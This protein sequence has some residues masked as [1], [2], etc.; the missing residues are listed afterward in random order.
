MGELDLW[1]DLFEVADRE[2]AELMAKSEKGKKPLP[3]G[4]MWEIKR[5]KKAGRWVMEEVAVPN[6]ARLLKKIM[7]EPMKPRKEQLGMVNVNQI[8]REIETTLAPL[9][10]T[11]RDLEAKW[12]IDRL[13]SL[14]PVDFAQRFASARSKLDDAI[15]EGE[16]TAV[17]KRAEIMQRGWIKLDE[18]AIEAGHKPNE[19]PEMW[20]GQQ[21]NGKKFLVVRTQEM[22]A[23]AR[24]SYGQEIGVWTLKEIGKV[25]EQFDPDGV[26]QMLKESFGGELVSVNGKEPF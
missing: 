7:D 13:P 8:S 5:V 22:V 17:E 19:Q 16:V 1:K 10:K 12:G 6:Q 25:L 21:P 24:Q 14:V 18:M 15:A 23:A 3:E 20:E 2:W 4:Y 11:Q 26:A 9:K